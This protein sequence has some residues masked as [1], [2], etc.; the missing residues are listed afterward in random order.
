MYRLFVRRNQKSGC[1]Y[2]CALISLWT[3]LLCSGIGA[4][5]QSATTTSKVNPP[6]SIRATH[7]IGFPKHKKQLQRDFVG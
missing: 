3:L 7:L 5:A 2:G 1:F 6:F 4:S